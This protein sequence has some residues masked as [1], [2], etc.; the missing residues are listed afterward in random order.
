MTFGIIKL[1]SDHVSSTPVTGYMTLGP[2]LNLS[3]TMYLRLWN[4]FTCYADEWNSTSSYGAFEY[5]P[6]IFIKGV[7]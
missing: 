3:L 4:I 7:W 6:V 2:L 5:F 1:Y